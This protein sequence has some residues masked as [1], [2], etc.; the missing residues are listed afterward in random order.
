MMG[1]RIQGLPSEN[2]GIE[3]E[4]ALSTHS[5]MECEGRLPVLSYV[6]SPPEN[7]SHTVLPDLVA[8]IIPENAPGT[9]NKLVSNYNISHFATLA[10]LS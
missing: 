5:L 4:Q 9:V 3:R 7:Q 10:T 6:Y 2:Y 8:A 1:N